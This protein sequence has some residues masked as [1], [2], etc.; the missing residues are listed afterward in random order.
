MFIFFRIS[1]YFPSDTG[2]NDRHEARVKER[3]CTVEQV[4][5]LGKLDGERA[6]RHTFLLI[7]QTQ[8]KCKLKRPETSASLHLQKCPRCHFCHILA[9]PWE[10]TTATSQVWWKRTHTEWSTMTL[11]GGFD[12]P[13]LVPQQQSINRSMQEL[14]RKG[15]PTVQPNISLRPQHTLMFHWHKLRP[16]AL[17]WISW[18]HPLICH[19]KRWT[20]DTTKKEENTTLWLYS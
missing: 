8:D 20:P 13:L 15:P 2:H 1:W 6:W 7:W 19:M 12:I 5:K 10:L 18:T 3:T 11:G 9:S 16:R 4:N 14:Q 17:D